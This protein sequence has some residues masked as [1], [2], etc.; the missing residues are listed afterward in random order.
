MESSLAAL[1]KTLQV[2][3]LADSGSCRMPLPDEEGRKSPLSREQ[4][5]M[6][7]DGAKL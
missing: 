2:K 7:L 3:N 6:V 4:S 1:G 5:D